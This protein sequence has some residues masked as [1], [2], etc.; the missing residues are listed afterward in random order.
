MVIN[1]TYNISV[2]LWR[3][4]LLLEDTRVPGENHRL[5]QVNDKIYCIMLYRVHF[6]MSGIRTHNVSGDSHWLHK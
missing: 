4:L 2:I 6:P 3:S 1:A 5:S